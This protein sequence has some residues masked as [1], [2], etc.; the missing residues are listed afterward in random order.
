[1]VNSIPDTEQDDPA[2]SSER[3]FRTDHLMKDLKGHSVRG[4]A[5]TIVTQ[6][7]KFILQMGSTMVLARLLTPVDYGLV[8]MV[9]VVTG[10]LGIIKD[11]GLS[12]ATVQRES[13]THGQVSTLFWINVVFSALLMFF[14]AAL[15][16]AIAWFYQEPRL[17]AITLVLAGSFLFAGLTVQ[18]S[19]LLRRQMKFGVLAVIDIMS[20]AIGFGIGI[21][22]AILTSSYWA[23]VGMAV[24][25]SV[26]SCLGHWLASGWMPGLPRRGTGVMPMLRFGGNLTGFNFVSHFGRNTD[27]FLIGWWWGAGPLGIYT[28]AYGLLMVPI[29]QIN[30]PF[31]QVALPALSRLKASPLEYKQFYCQAVFAITSVG[32]PLVAAALCLIDSMVLLILGEQWMGAVPVFLALGPAALLGTFNVATGWVY[33]SIGHVHIQFRWGGF[34]AFILA[35]AFIIGLPGGPVSVAIAYSIAS[36]I[37]Y[38]IGVYVCFRKTCLSPKDL[39]KAIR[40]PFAASALASVTILTIRNL[41]PELEAIGELLV[42]GTIFS[43]T[44]FAV[45]LILSG[46]KAQIKVLKGFLSKKVPH[47]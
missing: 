24:V 32:V 35:L 47:E 33:Q 11:A 15:A 26:V 29:Y 27:R 17:T 5:I 45:W 8:A 46:R 20:M 25:G 12:A 19:A 31:T 2:N 34:S 28:K 22:I 10:S 9:T 41:T 23:L 13:I 16:P 18:H 3:H 40:I 39:I 44:Y 43:V 42:L 30:T 36:I 38:P 14:T 6:G 1:M 4:G 21:V 7:L 37:M